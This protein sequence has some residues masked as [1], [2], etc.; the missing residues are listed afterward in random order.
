MCDPKKLILDKDLGENH[1]GVTILT[2][3]N[4]KSQIMIIWNGHCHKQ[5]LRVIVYY[6][7]LMYMMNIT[8]RR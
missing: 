8:L 3:P 1:V 5:F 2:C 6:H 4:D 7:C